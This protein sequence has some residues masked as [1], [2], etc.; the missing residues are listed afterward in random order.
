MRQI[1][2]DTE[3]T[4]LHPDQGHRIIEI[5]CVEIVNRRLS[6]QHFHRY[7]NPGRSSDPDALK[8]HGLGDEFLRDQPPFE[9]I[10]D[11]LLAFVS[12]AEVIIHNAPFDVG[13]LD[14]E[15][16]R[17]SRGPFA[18]HVEGIIDSLAMAK[19]QF[20]GKRNS[21]DA[22]CARFAIDNSHRTLHG[23]LL[24]A[25]LLADVYLTMTRGQD[26]LVIDLNSA[27]PAPSTGVDPSSL[28]TVKDIRVVAATAE[29]CEE[30]ARVLR[31]VARAAGG[32]AVW[33]EPM[34]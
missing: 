3:T 15:L 1:I 28:P 11:E 17:V 23:A 22:L 18:R 27:A 32:R 14:M 21:L 20:P 33:P 7:V 6:G 29:E 2:L 34:A 24:D 31:D 19:A 8:V 10:V 16:E 25:E 5:G 4:G 30:H 26:S 13:F 9:A 12:G